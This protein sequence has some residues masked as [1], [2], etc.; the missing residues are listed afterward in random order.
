MKLYDYIVTSRDDDPINECLD[1]KYEGKEWGEIDRGLHV[2]ADVVCPKC[3]SAH[4]Y[5]KGE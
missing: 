1:C 4:Y 5:I 3:G 2:C